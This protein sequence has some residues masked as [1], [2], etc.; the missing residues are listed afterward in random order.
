MNTFASGEVIRVVSPP[1]Q[2]KVEGDSF[3][4]PS[5][6]P[7]RI[8]HLI[9]AADFA[10]LPASHRFIIA[11]NFR[12]DASQMEPVDWTSGNE[13]VW[14][15]T[16]DRDELTN[17]FEDNHGPDRTLVHDG[18]LP[19]PLL[20]TG[21]LEGPRDFAD[22]PRLDTPF[23]YDPSKGNLLIDRL[24]F[25]NAPSP[26]ASIDTLFAA[27]DLV[28]INSTDPSSATGT[29]FTSPA[30]FQFEF[31]AAPVPGD[32]NY[33]SSVDAVDYVVWR[34]S[35]GAPAGTLPNDIDGGVIGQAQYNTWKSH[36]GTNSGT[37]SLTTK[38]A[39]VPEPSAA[40]LMLL[41]SAS[42]HWRV[43]YRTVR[44]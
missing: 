36:F 40:V 42:I 37:L 23:F 13:Q 28:L 7:I 8:Q 38:S 3:A 10:D 16:T 1:A 5:A 17:V 14:M 15:S 34:D 21:P 4:T 20:V 44:V 19:F 11:F 26:R 12:A 27:Q 6:A 35:V 32:Y 41:F 9:P 2:E 39:V 33:D 29:L 18:A 22:G 24:V 30:V 31:E 43:R 25:G